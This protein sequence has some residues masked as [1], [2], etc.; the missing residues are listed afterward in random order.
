MNPSQSGLAVNVTSHD[1]TF[2][3]SV[4]G[5]VDIPQ[6]GGGV[7]QKMGHRREERTVK[8]GQ[9]VD[10]GA[11]AHPRASSPENNNNVDTIIE[12]RTRRAVVPLWK[13]LGAAYQERLAAAQG[14]EKSKAL[15]RDAAE[16]LALKVV[17]EGLAARKLNAGQI[18]LC[19]M[20]YG[21]ALEIGDDDETAFIHMPGSDERLT[22][23]KGLDRLAE[24]FRAKAAAK[25][26]K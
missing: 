20:A 3:V 21:S 14:A 22:L 12:R 19:L 11:Y 2:K 4:P 8:S 23:E 13:P 1:V 24:E 10:V 16:D 18:E 15:K 6:R 9:V 7:A 26:K 25:G 17:R 5:L